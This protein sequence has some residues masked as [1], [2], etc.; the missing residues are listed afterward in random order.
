MEDDMRKSRIHQWKDARFF[1]II[2]I[3][4]LAQA[5]GLA[6]FSVAN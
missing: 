5:L 2:S 4:G 1:H 6:L 3:R